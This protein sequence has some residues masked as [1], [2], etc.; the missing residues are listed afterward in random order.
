M[1]AKRICLNCAICAC[2]D[3]ANAASVNRK[4]H[5]C[6]KDVTKCAQRE[7]YRRAIWFGDWRFARCD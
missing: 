7:E 1:N 5:I 3:E 6:Y 2:K 4:N